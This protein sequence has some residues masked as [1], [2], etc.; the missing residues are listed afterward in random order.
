M[1]TFLHIGCGPK[2]KERTSRGFNTDAWSEIRLDIDPSVSP[3]V[4]GTMTDMA[5]VSAGSINALPGV[6]K[7]EIADSNV[8]WLH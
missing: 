2:R 5:S 8:L 3:D 6:A 1:K 4:T 7:E